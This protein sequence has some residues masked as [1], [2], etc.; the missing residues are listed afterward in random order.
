MNLEEAE[1]LM[2]DVEVTP[3]SKPILIE[4]FKNSFTNRRAWIVKQKP[5]VSEIIER[6]PRFLDFPEAV[7]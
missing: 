7:C 2:K 1:A 6:F 4:A 5:L 3:N